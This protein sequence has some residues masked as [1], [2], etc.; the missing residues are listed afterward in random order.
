MTTDPNGEPQQQL[1][2]RPLNERAQAE[3]FRI[4]LERGMLTEDDPFGRKALAEMAYGVVSKAVVETPAERSEKGV[5][6]VQLMG[7]FFPEVPGR[8]RWVEAEDP[9]LAQAVYGVIAR[10]VGKVLSVEPNGL[11]QMALAENGGGVLCWRPKVQGVERLAYVTRNA[12]CIAEDN[13]TPAENAAAKAVDKAARRAALAVERVPESGKWFERN[14]RSHMRG[15]L[16]SGQ[17][18]VRAAIEAAS[19]DD[20]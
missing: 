1:D 7:M 19:G 6:L 13:N 18:T 5:S 4:F 2:L 11:V 14:Y 16:E 20:A 15:A 12:K 9:E 3:M 17:Q 10:E 8:D